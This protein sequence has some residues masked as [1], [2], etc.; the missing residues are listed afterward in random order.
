MTDTKYIWK[1]TVTSGHDSFGPQALG[2]YDTYETA[3]KALE[4]RQRLDDL[5]HYDI[6][7]HK[8]QTM[9]DIS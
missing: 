8:I 4:D 5:I 2:Y 3:K 7:A 9:Q 1:V 6:S